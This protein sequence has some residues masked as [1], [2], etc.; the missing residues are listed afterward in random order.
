MGCAFFMGICGVAVH[1]V[2]VQFARLEESSRSRLEKWPI[3]KR[4]EK[5][6]LLDS[7]IW[8]FCGEMYEV[9][10]VAKMYMLDN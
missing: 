1:N 9:Q 4:P 5:R 6:C 3:I 10:Q 2:R 8:W 7:V